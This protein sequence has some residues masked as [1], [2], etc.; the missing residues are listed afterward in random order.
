MHPAETGRRYDALAET[1]DRETLDSRYGVAYVR[2]AI[3]ACVIRACVERRET[4]PVIAQNAPSQRRYSLLTTLNL[5]TS[6]SPDSV[7]AS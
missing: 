3:R 4:S 5:A 6:S 1:W 2:R 7:Q